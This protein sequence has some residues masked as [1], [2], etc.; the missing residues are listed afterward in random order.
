M[1]TDPGENDPLAPKPDAV[2]LAG[3]RLVALD[4]RRLLVTLSILCV[5]LLGQFISL[6]GIDPEAISSQFGRSGSIAVYSLMALGPIPW[7]TATILIE[8]AGTMVPPLRRTSLFRDEHADPF[9]GMAI[10]VTL[11]IGGLQAYGI[12]IA[13]EAAGALDQTG[14]FSTLV[15]I[16]SLLGG[17]VMCVVLAGLVERHG[18]GHGFWLLFGI[19]WLVALPTAMFFF[20]ESV[21]IGALPVLE[22]SVLNLVT[23]AALIGLTVYV[24]IAAQRSGLRSPT[25]ILMPLLVASM[26]SSFLVS[27]VWA[28]ASDPTGG[29]LVGQSASRL[30]LVQALLTA[31]LVVPLLW[32]NLGRHGAR[33]MLPSALVLLIICI[34]LPT[35]SIP[36]MDGRAT[37]RFD[38]GPPNQLV[39]MIAVLVLFS[40]GIYG[41]R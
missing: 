35:I 32:L 24:M 17:T 38:L 41:R 13:L 31:L 2:A 27:L 15:A 22:S 28:I 34:A 3:G 12:V 26:A 10:V 5:F 40:R 18:I 36:F 25:A 20:L 6:P 37:W 19:A 14:A 9:S 29:A 7:F 4:W 16:A 8:L 11:A 30:V 21:R 39:A 1:Q 23:L 33:A